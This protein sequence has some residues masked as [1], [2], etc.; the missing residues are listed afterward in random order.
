MSII[1]LA[2]AKRAARYTGTAT[3]ADDLTFAD[4]VNALTP[5][6]E[7]ACG[8]I[9]LATRTYTTSCWGLNEIALPW[10]VTAITSVVLDGVTLTAA[11]PPGWVGDYDAVT[12]A[13]RAILRP[14]PYTYPRWS[15][16]FRLVV[17]AVVGS[18]TIPDNIR[19]AAMELVRHWW[20]IG[21]QGG[22]PG[23][24]QGFDA[25]LISFDLPAR[26]WQLLEPNPDIGGF[27]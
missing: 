17:T 4:M 2:E 6:L 14:A 1:T 18:A 8:P 12:A 10:R 20:Q 5:V 11:S 21:Q 22:Q 19:Q 15:Y 26:V 3:A 27:G 25:A 13:D 7:N 23:P 24:G 16:G 9:E